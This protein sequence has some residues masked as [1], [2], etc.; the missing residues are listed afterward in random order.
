ME[1]RPNILFCLADDASPSV[2]LWPNS[3]GRNFASKTTLAS[4]ATAHR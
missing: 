3:C 2:S 1:K 4:P